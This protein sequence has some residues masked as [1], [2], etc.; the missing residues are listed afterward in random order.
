M[1]VAVLDVF[2]HCL[3]VEFRRAVERLG[4]RLPMFER[5]SQIRVMVDIEA[6]LRLMD[7]FPGYRQILSLAS[8]TVETLA[9]P[10]QAAELAQVGNDSL[11]SLVHGH[12]DHFPGFIA[13]LPMN[14][15]DA[16]VA[17]AERA[18][19]QLGAVGLQLYTNVNGAPLDAAPQRDVLESLAALGRPWWLHPIR[20][21]SF[22]DYATESSSQ[23]DVWWAFG[24]PYE[25]SVAMLRLVCA[26]LFDR[27]PNQA[28]VTH[29]AGGLIPVMA[30]RIEFGLDVRALRNPPEAMHIAT[31]E[32]PIAG[33]RRFFA[34]T[35][36][37][38]SRIPLD[39]ARQFFGVDKLLFASDMPFDPEEGP[40][41]I[42]AGLRL[43]DE[44][45]LTEAERHS[46]RCGNAERL[47]G[48]TGPIPM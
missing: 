35:A 42:R 21:P 16:A 4:R 26:G 47:L 17:E 30:G 14:D 44:M 12:P 38:G 36:S 11:A 15:P 34:D 43:L 20:P 29:H 28:I 37:F 3:P 23:L 8:P 45:D 31:R 18:V 13:S 7:E 48:L 39:A 33:L 9:A 46:I 27:W 19:R 24:W 1:A 41:F 25:T 32:P 6:R 10:K 40:G 5:A 2:C 22:A